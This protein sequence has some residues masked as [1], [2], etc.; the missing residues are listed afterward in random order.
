MTTSDDIDLHITFD[1][2]DPRYAVVRWSI[3]EVQGVNAVAKVMAAVYIDLCASGIPSG[4]AATM[5]SG[6][7]TSALTAAIARSEEEE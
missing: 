6:I 1:S 2:T 4:D 5:A 7:L 3:S